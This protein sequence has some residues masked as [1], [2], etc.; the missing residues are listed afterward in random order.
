M[1]GKIEFWT[2]LE[3][4]V[5]PICN[6]KNNNKEYDYKLRQGGPGEPGIRKIGI[7]IKGKL[8][9]TQ[10]KLLTEIF[11]DRFPPCIG[12]L[13]WNIETDEACIVIE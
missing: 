9:Q 8:K 5:C 4:E 3:D 1:H 11:V 2:L 12:M 7:L 10:L 13:L 6:I